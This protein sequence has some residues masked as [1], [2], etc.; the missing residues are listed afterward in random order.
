[1]LF[2]PIQTEFEMLFGNFPTTWANDPQLPR[3]LQAFIVLYLITL[4]L[5]VLNFL[6]AIIVGE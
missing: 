2:A 4:F 1:M 5:L 3:D 6:L